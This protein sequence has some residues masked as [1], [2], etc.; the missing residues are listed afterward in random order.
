MVYEAGLVADG[1]S[2]RTG[3]LVLESTAV[4]PLDEVNECVAGLER[5]VAEEH[6]ECGLQLPGCWEIEH[7]KTAPD[8]KLPW[9]DAGLP[10]GIARKVAGGVV[11]P[12]A[13]TVGLARAAIDQGAIIR[14]HALVTRIALEPQ[15][16]VEVGGSRIMPGHVVIATNAWINATLDQTPLLRSCLTFAVATA[17]LEAAALDAIGL[18]AGVPFYT[19]DMPYL[20]GR[21]MAGGVIFG[22]GLVFG[23]APE[24]EKTDVATGE[25]QAVLERLMRRV[26][27]LHPRLS[28]VKFTNAWGGPIAF[29]EGAVPILGR[30]PRDSRI[31]VSGAYAG[32]GVAL[33]VRAGE[34]MALAIA[35][36]RPLPKWGS[37]ER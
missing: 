20:W 4:G 3:G 1:A 33:S 25:S 10:V 14:E 34:L 5:E 36:N 22:S 30:H 8:K 31:L 35:E 19:S 24:L 16:A 27:G 28:E 18:G 32:H 11:Q 26:R 37:L 15:L 12:V 21:T 13:L 9:N 23:A 29:T 7:R 6:I 17:P 2:G